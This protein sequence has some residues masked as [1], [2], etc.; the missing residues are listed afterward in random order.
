MSEQERERRWYLILGASLR[1]NRAAR[2]MTIYDVAAITG[3]TGVA[4]SRWER[5]LRHMKAYQYNLLR[6]EGL[7]SD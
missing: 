2:G 3:T 5:G 6:R 1:F 4:V 7:L